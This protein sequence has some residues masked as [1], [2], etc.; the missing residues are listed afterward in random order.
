MDR[1]ARLPPV[2]GARNPSHYGPTLRRNRAAN[3]TDDS[4]QRSV[5]R[6]ATTLS[7]YIYIYIIFIFEKKIHLSKTSG[8]GSFKWQT[9]RHSFFFAA[10]GVNEDNLMTYT[11]TLIYLP[12]PSDYGQ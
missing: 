3:R 5:Q 1:F 8:A 2:P 9:C 11:L 4:I 12:S 10:D 6:S 7:L